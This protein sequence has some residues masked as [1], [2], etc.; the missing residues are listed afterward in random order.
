MRN[1]ALPSALLTLV[2]LCS[3]IAA[4]PAIAKPASHALFAYFEYQGHPS[5]FNGKLLV[6]S[7]L[8]TEQDYTRP[9][10]H[11]LPPADQALIELFDFIGRADL[12]LFFDDSDVDDGFAPLDPQ[13]PAANDFILIDDATGNFRGEFYLPDPPG[14]YALAGTVAVPAPQPLALFTAALAVLALLRL[15]APSRH[16]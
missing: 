4:P 1:R 5:Y 3:C 15:R 2:A 6:A 8:S 12:T 14:V 9:M 10:Q 16:A 11:L 13:A 7:D